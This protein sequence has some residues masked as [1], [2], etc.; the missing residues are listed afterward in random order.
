MDQAIF[1]SWICGILINLERWFVLWGPSFYIIEQTSS[2]LWSSDWCEMMGERHW[3]HLTHSSK[4]PDSIGKWEQSYMLRSDSKAG[5]PRPGA[6]SSTPENSSPSPGAGEEG[7]GTQEK[8]TRSR[9]RS[10]QWTI[11]ITRG[12]L[13]DHTRAC[14]RRK[15]AQKPSVNIGKTLEIEA[16]IHA[17]AN[18]ELCMVGCKH[19]CFC[20]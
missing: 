17:W 8:I 4:L 9:T 1:D 15:L 5:H 11:E 16:A 18:T 13:H 20:G 3:R 14:Q 12:W 19:W 2:R 6:F 10:A 7:R